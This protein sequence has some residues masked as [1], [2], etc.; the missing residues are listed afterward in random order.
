VRNEVRMSAPRGNRKV[1]A[2][3]ILV[4]EAD[5]EGWPRR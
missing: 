2:G 5:V 4:L 1:R 3:D